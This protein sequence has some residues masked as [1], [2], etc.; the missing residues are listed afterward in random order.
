MT[1]WRQ[2][3]KAIIEA[4]DDIGQMMFSVG[5]GLSDLRERLSRLEKEADEIWAP[6][7]TVKR[8]YYQAEDRFNGA[9]KLQRKFSLSANEWRKVR[10]AVLD[11]A[12][13]ASLQECRQRHE[14]T[15]VELKKLARIRRIH[16]FRAPQS[17][18]WSGRSPS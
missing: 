18:S 6:R 1:G 12:E 7:R 14:A 15:S 16:A 17:V 11:D 3:G 5:T 10:K 8:R 2:G 4:K 13:K 9:T